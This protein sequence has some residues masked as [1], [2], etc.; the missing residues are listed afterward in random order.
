MWKI[1]VMMHKKNHINSSFSYYSYMNKYF[2]VSLAFMG[3]LI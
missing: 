1:A 2:T 3:Y